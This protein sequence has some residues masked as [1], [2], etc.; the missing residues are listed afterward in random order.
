MASP[1]FALNDKLVHFLIFG[2]LATLVCRSPGLKRWGWAVLLVSAYG[3]ADEFRQSFTPGRYVEFDD[4][5]ADTSGAAVAVTLYTLWAGYRRL[6]ET[7]LRWP[8]RPGTQSPQPKIASSSP[9][10]SLTP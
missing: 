9:S 5:V 1:G 6:L 10:V 3:I 7:P 8:H 4:W 2:L